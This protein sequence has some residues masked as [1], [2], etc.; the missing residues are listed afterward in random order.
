ML[1]SDLKTQNMRCGYEPCGHE[2]TMGYNQ[3]DYNSVNNIYSVHQCPVCKV[4]N[5]SFG[6]YM[7]KHYTLPKHNLSLTPQ[8]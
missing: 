4:W 3:S 1:V 2:G 7:K 5:Y 8:P 6:N